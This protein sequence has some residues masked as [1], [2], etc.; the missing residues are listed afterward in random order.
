M[1]VH[2]V[3]FAM[4]CIDIFLK[5][6]TWIYF[7]QEYSH[8]KPEMRQCSY[9]NCV[10]VRVCVCVCVYVCVFVSGWVSG[11]VGRRGGR[12]MGVS[13]G[14]GGGRNGG[15]GQRWMRSY[16][17]CI[18]AF[19]AI[20]SSYLL[21]WNEP[22]NTQWYRAW[23]DFHSLQIHDHCFVSD[24]DWKGGK[25]SP[26][27]DCGADR[28]LDLDFNFCGNAC[29]CIVWIFSQGSRL[30]TCKRPLAKAI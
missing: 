1:L 23:V 30:R 12:E 28:I 5:W 24:S 14:G 13:R 21:L 25:Y 10:H 9:L 11:Y 19:I 17:L 7:N 3:M 29:N 6:M 16:F 20:W 2:S 4:M 8:R 22:V 18:F 27:G 15:G 26:A